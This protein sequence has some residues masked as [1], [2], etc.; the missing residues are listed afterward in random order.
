MRARAAY[1]DVALPDEVFTRWLDAL[2]GG[3]APHLEDLYLACGAAA[4]SER[5]L[6]HF[7]ALLTPLVARIY[8]RHGYLPGEAGDF[9]EL[10]REKLLVGD[11]PKI[12]DSTVEGRSRPGSA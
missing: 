8:R 3:E 2:G 7:D 4:G 5:A 10:V 11:G 1:P 6:F 9:A 12:R